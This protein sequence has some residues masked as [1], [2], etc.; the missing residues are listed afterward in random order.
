MRFEHRCKMFS[1]KRHAS[2]K[3]LVTGSSSVRAPFIEL[4]GYIF[5]FFSRK[6]EEL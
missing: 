2:T 3:Y 6:F 1:V 4:N 5:R